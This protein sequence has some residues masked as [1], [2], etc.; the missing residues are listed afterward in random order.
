MPC[1]LPT[2]MQSLT[3]ARS[4]IKAGEPTSMLNAVVLLSTGCRSLERESFSA[5][6][7]LVQQEGPDSIG[8]R[9]AQD[10][11]EETFDAVVEAIGCLSLRQ[12]DDALIATTRSIQTWKTIEQ[13][14]AMQS[15]TGEIQ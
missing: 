1:D 15:Y 8:A 13:L 14:Y 9:L 11:L 4:E 12:F 5:I 3:R 7:K 10:I 6:V 2:V